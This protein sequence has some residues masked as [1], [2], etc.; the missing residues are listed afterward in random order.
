MNFI[1][2]DLQYLCHCE[3]DGY[4]LVSTIESRIFFLYCK[5]GVVH[6]CVCVVYV[7]MCVCVRRG[8]KFN[9][10][11][12]LCVVILRLCRHVCVCLQV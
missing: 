9:N 10:T 2:N 12:Y 5:L 6:V 11:Y 1:R 7:S 4:E 8:C 3:C